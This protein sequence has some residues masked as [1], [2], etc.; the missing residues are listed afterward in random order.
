MS[1]ELET[2]GVGTATETQVRDD[3]DV[4]T[5][6]DTE[7]AEDTTGDD[8]ALATLG[9]AFEEHDGAEGD[10]AGE[11]AE[12]GDEPAGE[13][14][15]TEDAGESGEALEPELLAAASFAG[16]EEKDLRDAIAAVG[17]DK[18]VA[19]LSSMIGK[20]SERWG[21]QTGGGQDAAAQQA[22]QQAQNQQTQQQQTQQPPAAG[23]PFAVFES[24]DFAKELVEDFPE[25]KPL[26]ESTR[27]IARI[28]RDQREVMV[29]MANVLSN[30][31]ETV[32]N[33]EA[34]DMMEFFQQVDPDGTIYGNPLAQPTPEQLA[35]RKLLDAGARQYQRSAGRPMR[36]SAAL[37]D[38]HAALTIG[39]KNKAPSGRV[40][41]AEAAQ[42]KR[43][44]LP[45]SAGTAAP[46]GTSSQALDAQALQTLR[47]KYGIK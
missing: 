2:T 46:K 41:A 38:A 10:D 34:S 18:A 23:D 9:K 31:M 25:A 3:G 4:S 29:Q 37:K 21:I 36:F 19:M 42:K 15:K 1:E 11:T 7:P 47:T 35:A 13:E 32:G 28:A 24:P 27:Q 39:N 44:I 43:D 5:H 12:G 8:A 16:L 14:P 17:K 33:G 26:V 20:A 6:T 30:I 45:R 22:A 40:Q